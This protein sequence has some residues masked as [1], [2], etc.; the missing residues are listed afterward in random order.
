MFWATSTLVAK[1][2]YL[3]GQICLSAG[4]K[5]I[6]Q[7]HQAKSC[8]W[9]EQWVRK[10]FLKRKTFA[11]IFT[12]PVCKVWGSSGDHGSHLVW[13]SPPAWYKL[14]EKMKEPFLRQG[15]MTII[16]WWPHV[17]RRQH[18]WKQAAKQAKPK[19]LNTVPNSTHTSY[20]HPAAAPSQ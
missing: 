10:I 6:L 20:L 4:G 19:Q 11:Q 5:G 3:I 2:N 9:C 1:F 12:R 15:A 7:I 16:S 18:Y 13:T 14:L 8:G 17:S